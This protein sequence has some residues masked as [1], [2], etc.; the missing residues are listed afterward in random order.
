MPEVRGYKILPEKILI[1]VNAMVRL[2]NLKF[3]SSRSGPQQR[4]LRSG[5]MDFL[6]D[7][8]HFAISDNLGMIR[9]E[10]QLVSVIFD[11]TLSQL[12]HNHVKRYVAMHV[13][14]VLFLK[15]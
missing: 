8:E 1:L 7:D 5:G 14:A 2:S 13:C 11:F 15:L 4:Q 3:T 6:G 12:E 10:L 9:Y